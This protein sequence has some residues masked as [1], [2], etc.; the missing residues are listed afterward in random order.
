MNTSSLLRVCLRA[1]LRN[2]MRSALT[3]LGIIIGVAAVVSMVAI[4]TGKADANESPMPGVVTVATAVS[5][6]RQHVWGSP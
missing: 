2:K 5:Q 1:L 3:M 6:S 4:T